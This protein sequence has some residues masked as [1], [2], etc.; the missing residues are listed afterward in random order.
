MCETLRSKRYSASL[1]GKGV[2]VCGGVNHRRE[3]CLSYLGK[4]WE[5]RTETEMASLKWNCHNFFA[6]FCIS[7]RVGFSLLQTAG[8]KNPCSCVEPGTAWTP[9]TQLLLQEWIWPS[10][11]HISTFGAQNALS[12][13]FYWFL[14]QTKYHRVWAQMHYSLLQWN[15]K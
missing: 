10:E 1:Q 9:G 12:E 11:C 8:K 14:W 3:T 6:V 2:C 15:Y 5:W 7:L 13:N 4:G